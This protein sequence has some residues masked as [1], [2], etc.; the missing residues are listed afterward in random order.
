M[1]KVIA[2][3]FLAAWS[4]NTLAEGSKNLTPSN[5]GT[6]TGTNTF[7]GYL[8][9]DTNAGGIDTRTFF[10]PQ[11]PVDERVY[12]YMK[13]GETLYWGLNRID[14]GSTNQDLTVALFEFGDTP[15]VE[16]PVSTWSLSA[17][18]NPNEFT[19]V[20]GPGVIHTYAEAAAG[21][22]IL[23]GG[24]YD[25]NS[26]TNN[27][28]TDQDFFIVFLQANGGPNA[29]YTNDADIRS[30]YD[31]WDFS[32][33]D[34]SQEKTGR[35]HSKRL[36][37]SGDG[38][39]NL[40]STEFQLYSLIPSTVG[41][42]NAGYYVKEMDLSGMAPWSLAVYANSTGADLA[43][44]ADTNGDGTI[45]FLD[46]RQ[47]QT[48]DIGFKEYDIFINNPDIEIYP[49]NTLPTVTIT[50]ANIHCNSSGTGGEASITF[51]SN[52][53][54]QIAIIV[55]LNGVNGYQDGTTDV[56]IEALVAA[57]G[58]SIV[59]WDGLDGLGATVASGTA[60]SIT[61]RFTS[62]PLHVPLYDVENNTAGIRMLDVRPATSFD[63][64]FW[65]DSGAGIVTNQTP[66]VEL[67]GSNTNNHNWTGTDFNLHN[68][69]SFG[70]Y[71]V[72]TQSINF[73]YTCDGDAD[74]TSSI[75]DGDSDNDGLSD[76][77]E[78]DWDND[79]DVDGIL[80]YVDTDLA[81]Y[82]DSNGDGVN[83]NFDFDLD[84]IPNALDLD[85][86]N[87]GVPD[88]VESGQT[89]ADND[90][91]V[92]GFTDVSGGSFG[93]GSFSQYTISSGCSTTF[94][95][96][97]GHST[98]PTAD[99]T[100]ITTN[101]PFDFDFYG[102]LKTAGS[103]VT[104]APNG[105]FSFDNLNPGGNGNDAPLV[106]DATYTNTVLLNIQDWDPSSG[107]TVTYGVNGAGANE[108]FVYTFTNVPFW[109]TTGTATVQMQLHETTNEIRILTSNFN[110]GNGNNQTMGLNVDGSTGDAISGR[111]Q[112]AYTITVAECQ[113]FVPVYANGIDD[114]IDGVPITPTSTDA[115][116]LADYLD[117]DSDNDGIVDAIEA[118][119]TAGTDGQISG[120]TD[121]DGNGWNDTQ[122]SAALALTNSDAD[123]LPNYLDIDSDNDGIIDNIEGQSS[124][125][126][127]TFAAGDTNANGLLDIYD[128]NNGGTLIIPVDTDSN[129]SEDY[130]DSDA[131][132]D[133]VEDLIEGHDANF[134]GFGDWDATGSNN[135]IADEAGY[136]VDTDSDGL[137][138]VF[139][140]DNG[141]T[142]AVVQN[143]DGADLDNFQDTDDDNDGKLTAGEDVNG[144]NDWTDDFT[145]GQGSGTPDYLYRGD[146]DG[147][148]IADASDADSDNDG[149]SDAIES[150]G[151]AI[152][153]SGDEDGDSV[154][155]YRDFTDG[156]V[157]GGLTSTN[158]INSDGVYDVF[159]SDLD[160]VP[161]FLDLDSDN[162]G[163]LDAIEAND[164][165]V[166]FGLNVTTGMFNLQDPDN[167]GLMN[168]IDSDGVNPGG[169]ST[170]ANS[171]SDSDGVRDYIDID[172][173][174]DGIVDIVEFQTS[175]GYIA[176]I[177]NDE[178]GDG[179]D[180]SFDPS[181]G[182]TL[183]SAV[184]SDGADV[185]DY[186]DTDS[187]NDGVL[188]II[189]GHDSDF[190]GYG[191]W[192]TNN[193][194]DITDE[195]N[196]NV[197]S[198]GDGLDDIFDT[199]TLGSGN[200][201]TGTNTSLQNTDGTDFKDWRD[202]ND[203]N[204]G[205]STNDEDNN[206]NG[207]WTDDQ[208]SGQPG[209]I[210]DY[211]YNGDFDMDLI[212]DALD[213][214]SDNDGIL[215]V[216][217]ANG[218]IVDP[219]GD[220]DSDGIP[221]FRDTDDPAVLNNI[222]EVDSNGDGVW[223]N[224]DS[225]LDGS[226]DFKDL[227]SDND[228]IPDL[229]EAGGTDV[230]G[231]GIIDGLDDADSDGIPDN[232]DV[233]VTGGV[234]SDLDGIDDLYDFSVSGGL[235]TDGDDII[236]TADLDINGNGL[237]NVYD[238]ADG[239]SFLVIR[240]FDG[241]GKIDAA[242]LDSDN[243]GLPDI[244][245]AGGTDADND[246]KVDDLTD[247]DS[248]G[249]A[250]A[251]DSDNGGTAYTIPDADGDGLY[252]YVDL[253]S[254][255]DG[256][257][258]ATES[259]L[260]DTDGDGI[261]DN[262]TDTDGDGWPDAADP[263]N[264][265][266]PAGALDDDN[267]G[268]LNHQDLDAD[269]DGLPDIVEAG[270]TD[271]DNDG[272]VDS[273]LDADA[274]G[275]PDNVDVTYFATN[276]GSGVDSD[277]D[278]I[279]NTFDVD[280]T[281]G[282]DDDGDGIDNTFDS[283]ADGNGLDDFV[284]SNPYDNL[285]TDGDGNPD[286]HDLDS[287]NDGIT[288]PYEYGETVD[289]ATGQLS[290]FTDANSNGW[291][292]AQEA[293]S[294]SP[295]DSDSDP[296]SL[297]DF[298]DLDSDDDG[299]P[300]NIEAQVR[301]SYIAPSGVDSDGDGLDDAYDPDNGGT[302]LV[303]VNT[304]GTGNVDFLDTDSDGDGINDNIEGANADRNQWADWDSDNDNNP[305]DETGWDADVDEDGI[306]D[307]FD[308]LNGTGLANITG[309]SS[310]VQDTDVDQIWDFQDDDDDGDG[311]LTSAEA[312]TPILD[313]DGI[314]P[315]YLYGNQDE[316]GDGVDNDEDE[317]ADNDG[318][319]NV[320]ESGGTGIDPSG[321]IDND[322]LYNYQDF[323]IDGDGT[324]NVADVDGD[325]LGTNTTGFTDANND[326]VIDQFD[327]D[328]DGTPDFRD[329]DSDNDG[330]MDLVESGQPDADN[331]GIVD[332]F[333]DVTGGG[334]FTSYTISSGCSTTFEST[335]G[336][337]TGPTGDDTYSNPAL[338][339]EV[340][341][342][343]ST[344][345]AGTT[346][347]LQSNGWFSFDNITN[348]NATN[349]VAIPDGTYTNTIF[350]NHRDWDPSAGG[351][352]TYGTNGT[353]P[354]RTFVVTY[355][356]V[357]FFGA[358]G[359][360]TVQMIIY[361]ATSE[362]RIITTNFN[363]DDGDNHTMGLNVDGGTG[364]A[365]TGRNQ[366]NYTITTAEC[367]SFVPNFGG[368]NGAHD[369]FDASPLLTVDTDADGID[370]HHDLDS[371]NDGISDNREGQTTAAYIAP[372][373]GDTDSNGVLDVY[374]GGGAFSPANTDGTDNADYLDADSDNDGVLDAI[375]GWDGNSNGF[376]DW[377][378]D[379]DNNITDETGYNVDSDNDGIWNIYDS[380]AGLGV[381]ANIDGTNQPIQDT[382]A[383]ATLDFRDTDDDEDGIL[384]SAE[385]TG[386]GMGGGAD[387][388]WTNDVTQGG[389][390]I[391]DY[392]FAPD[393]DGDGVLDAVDVDSDNDGIPNTIEYASAVYNA[394]GTPFDDADADGIYNYLDVNDVNNGSFVD[395][396]NDGVDDQVDQDRDGIPNFFDLDSDNDG[397]YDAV[398]ANDGLV[399][400]IGGFD[401]NT[402]IFS[403]TDVS[404]NDGEVDAI[405]ATPLNN[406]NLDGGSLSDYLD[407]DTDNDGITDNIEAQASAALVLPSG[408]DT[409]SDG[410]DDSYDNDNGG[411][412]ITPV[413]SDG[414]DE[415]DYRDVN[416][417]NDLSNGLTIPDFI[418]GFDANRNGFSDLDSDL[419][420]LISDE[421]GYNVDTDGDGLWNLFD[422]YSG[423]GTD[424]INSSHADLQDT[425]G[426]NTLDFRDTDDDQDYISTILEDVN[427]DGIW[428][429]DKVQGGGATPDYLYFNDSDNDLV[430][431]GQDQDGD[432]DGVLNDDEYFLTSIDPFGD[433]DAD[434][435]FNYNDADNPGGLTDSD[436]DGIWDEY[437]TDLDGIPNFFDLD[438]DNDG[439]PDLIENGGTDANNDG[440]LDG[441]ADSDNDGLLDT[442]DVDATLGTDANSDGI[443]D[444]YQDG[445]DVDSDGI[446]DDV[447]RD[448]D[449]DG[450][451][452][453]LDP[454]EGGTPLVIDDFDGDGI[455]NMFDKD[456]DNDGIVDLIEAGGN[457]S[458]GD[459]ILDT[460]GDTD[461]DGFSNVVDADNGGT[462]LTIPNTDSSN[463]A[464][465]LDF[466]ADGDNIFDYL[467]GFDDDEDGQ[468]ED[469]YVD[470]AIAYGNASHYNQ[471]DMVWF[472]TDSDGDDW[473]DF[474][475]PDSGR[476]DDSDGD[477]I[478]NLYDVDNGGNFYGNVS[479]K[480]DNDSDGKENYVDKD[481]DFIVSETY[482]VT[483]E[484]GASDSFDVSLNL[485]PIS[486]VV[487]SVFVTDAADEISIDK[488]SLT[489][490]TGDWNVPQTV[491]V[492]GQ[493][494]SD[495]DGDE[496]FEITLSVV[497]ASSDDDYDDAEN[498]IVDGLNEDN[499]GSIRV[500]TNAVTT[501]E[502]GSAVTFSVELSIAPATNVVVNIDDGSSDEGVVNPSTT[503]TFTSG[504]WD[505]PQDITVT[506]QDD[507]D[508]DGDQLFNITLS[509]DDPSSDDA[510]DAASDVIV[511]VT[512]E[513]DEEGVILSTTS[514]TTTE[515]GAT[516]SFS[517]V[518]DVMPSSDVFITI[519]ESSDEGSVSPTNITFGTGDWNVPQ[520]ITVTPA[521]D[522]D[523]DGNQI[524]A[525]TVSVGGGSD[526]AFLGVPDQ[527]VTVTNEDDETTPLPLDFL[528]FE[529][530][531][532][533]NGIVLDWTTANE[534]NVSHFE[535]EHSLDGQSFEVIGRE[536]AVNVPSSVNEYTFMHEDPS[537]KRNYY[538][539]KELDF[540][541]A[542]M[543]TNV[544]RVE[545]P[546]HQFQFN[547]YPNPVSDYLTI[548]ANEALES[549]Q[550]K[551]I[552]SIGKI[553]LQSTITNIKGSKLQLDVS[554]LT[555]GVYHVLINA[556]ETS[557][558]LRIIKN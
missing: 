140:T 357:S 37:F 286:S 484:S 20:D 105:W 127:I 53:S 363:P 408:T 490:G 3:L 171:D 327:K 358:G 117:M 272:K 415:P 93:A 101:L 283:D 400:G 529:G 297:A 259:R 16:T 12:V 497:D 110:P 553:L 516:G 52:Q 377:D 288:N 500:S 279:D 160:G 558:H 84:G 197:D 233:D 384:T 396:N 250:D 251:V 313:P 275:I 491:T 480:P 157:S 238:D 353:F 420:G 326:L 409:D 10:D 322:G 335:I 267:D 139:D 213:D 466:E 469:N 46:A 9:H 220:D 515:A 87:D 47:S 422:T 39:A 178:D 394:G 520:V 223:D 131:D 436:G 42:V 555:P 523:N 364:D 366:Q 487:I 244:I 182:G 434:G 341:F 304:D 511:A 15:G 148:A 292:D 152:D 495:Y 522:V 58:H 319:T 380:N 274:D 349:A 122:E 80:D 444:V 216:D 399:P 18:A 85:S 334:A 373:T 463:G 370:N 227:D 66:T 512:N 174:R 116:G 180:D 407:L 79:T 530:E 241:D 32:V 343:S 418:E 98:G 402:G 268:V 451:I 303:P 318:L 240:D 525:V 429:N 2:A 308:N 150:N 185:A 281:G 464:D 472:N 338:P 104:L 245:E 199:V 25:A 449:N 184:N 132:G 355:D 271:T 498:Q 133:G 510:F 332:G 29:G 390:S 159:D 94:E 456:S 481:G 181:T 158:D 329:L 192:D 273:A 138:D 201:A 60:L 215:D 50:D 196:Y 77:Q 539:I 427:G 433:A 28:G 119:G 235:D 144:N 445:P 276:G 73:D 190:N 536:K 336:H 154:P 264:G 170:L 293:S 375:E 284:E 352:V 173:D 477:G 368:Q 239:G 172:S 393:N 386:D 339:F 535:I 40:L 552:S 330:I 447:D 310:A 323:D 406:D 202:D 207:D 206:G 439:I 96:T 460:T 547:Y 88:I 551:V 432:Q 505:T 507:A 468:Y 169:N 13:D 514:V 331:D 249:F 493:D 496:S 461:G 376:A 204:D 397:I 412:P 57:E 56:I 44:V 325:G 540:D 419:D 33:Y 414:T 431:D 483:N 556:F 295:P 63:L 76:A 387:G 361:E 426:D 232:V 21:P 374:E 142:A 129:G 321:D 17:S 186:L 526:A 265:G 315:D 467:E 141:G 100:E 45:D 316:D 120:F 49:T 411:T 532:L 113:S 378:T 125:S 237:P 153:P 75:F 214:D 489:F 90:G 162:D 479:G 443:D 508:L 217:E 314:I 229:V 145:E 134:D 91:K 350:M 423:R 205:A 401:L 219:S 211:L 459:G 345:A 89:D 389:G 270:G 441:L 518:L 305:T 527:T 218:E 440:R 549:A 128:P 340:D 524:Y 365:I 457:D 300:D 168:Y 107:G 410:L 222:V 118:G 301:A 256:V 521:D 371:D 226:P 478:V 167:D 360:G 486:D 504:D 147:D 228:G 492:T 372:A 67:D 62:G 176:A 22:S 6:A 296:F 546:Y 317:D 473:P 474:L 395:V 354:N 78:G 177:G 383:D 83:D 311:A 19:F 405:A 348:G 95:G 294:I 65:D 257:T 70:Y 424:N 243:D 82:L 550:I 55:D 175:A 435:I 428:T 27:T 438:S 72:N 471:L 382:D 266:F 416:S 195:A 462:P 234:D 379:S 225:D 194:N 224:F 236:D 494:D 165:E 369:T 392:L 306:F 36:G 359:T 503:L 203:D 465:Y 115:D 543:Y 30:Q 146:Y 230:D 263:D 347:T 542:Y 531:Y 136:N 351:T 324:A 519:S 430:A 1:R 541:G 485:Q 280:Q 298:V 68:T 448:D 398:E 191:D 212:A 417:D 255:N 513:D 112:Q 242:D 74:G 69:W 309:S 254:D 482:I 179:I 155:N 209:A 59:K 200:N 166:P 81:G 187:D 509:V 307:L 454:D 302:L 41:G 291:N 31:L 362:I 258:D 123:G 501:V 299:I 342:Y 458:N 502:G 388:I 231:N 43:A 413:N 92:D 14:V 337:T 269:N 111:N 210:P 102:D 312:T 246:G 24:G 367:Q 320:V 346:T 164:G 557:S 221:N 285:D 437:D 61:G 517:V 385:D 544:L 48:S 278:G 71:Q 151:E 455:Q 11:A 161:D 114:T 193:N 277:A 537:M 26:Y 208:T 356:N 260:G 4:W 247:S 381:I 403:G 261:V 344:I 499:E 130:F 488:S 189:E 103:T 287:D 290:G 109:N 282:S 137:W 86:D 124:S 106:P 8:E 404:P 533:V 188:D 538:R 548:E 475:D 97:G 421:T 7:I 135:D 34:G 35:L 545:S 253:D 64:I 54:G 248:D 163:M 554:E 425:D 442:Y 453:L 121:A 23:V 108:I 51:E 328:L 506:P 450:I 5:T 149:I 156:T 198:D 126:Y 143:S 528:S 262:A 333:T 99:D 252:D 183:I 391:P 534:M 452:D 38:G 446:E 289:P 470:R 476:Y